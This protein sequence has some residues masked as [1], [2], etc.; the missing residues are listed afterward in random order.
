MTLTQPTFDA[1][2]FRQTMGFFATGVTVIT[3]ENNGQAYGMTANAV[4][5]VS[6]EPLLLLVCVQKNAHLLNYLR[7]ATGFA[8]NILGEEQEELSQY[9]AHLWPHPEPPPFTFIP[10][11]GGPRLVGAIASIACKTADFLEGGD[12]WIVL[13]EVVNLYR[14]ENPGNPL[15]YYRG[16]Y[17][18]ISAES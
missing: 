10:W 11:E 13:G 8:I 2:A 14:P 4:A 15:L 3:V 17:R 16:H 1:H 5:S 18:R 9:F 7:Q 6:L 12:H